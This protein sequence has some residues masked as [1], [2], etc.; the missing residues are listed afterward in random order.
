MAHERHARVTLDC[1]RETPPKFLGVVPGVEV[2]RVEVTVRPI[3]HGMPVY[4]RGAEAELQGPEGPKQDA[5]QS[6]V[7]LRQAGGRIEVGAVGIM[8]IPLLEREQIRT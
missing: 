2:G 1:V 7:E 5:P 4:D 6:P 3:G 8:A